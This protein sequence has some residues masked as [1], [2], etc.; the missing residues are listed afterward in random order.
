M[1]KGHIAFTQ[2][3]DFA[4]LYV[5]VLIARKKLKLTNSP[6]E[7]IQYISLAPFEKRSIYHVFL[8]IENQDVKELK[9][10]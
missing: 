7:I 3:I 4:S 6:Y 8:S 10:I 1:N 5:L 2:I 9:Y